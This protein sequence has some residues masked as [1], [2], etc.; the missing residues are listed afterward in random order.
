MLLQTPNSFAC[1]VSLYNKKRR[2]SRVQQLLQQDSWCWCTSMYSLT[3]SLTS[4]VT[5]CVRIIQIL[6]C[7]ILFFFY[8]KRTECLPWLRV[9][10]T[11]VD[12]VQ[13]E[14][15]SCLIPSLSSCSSHLPLH[16]SRKFPDVAFTFILCLCPLLPL[17][18]S[19]SDSCSMSWVITWWWLATDDDG[20]GRMKRK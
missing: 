19:P 14:D 1:L 11:E 20:D 17:T 5:S 3:H 15:C 12:E 8:P 18:P 16:S 2:L 4:S 6:F 10:I 9:I 13:Q 7:R